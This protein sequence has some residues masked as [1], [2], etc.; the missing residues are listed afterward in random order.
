MIFRNISAR[1]SPL[2]SSPTRLETWRVPQTRWFAALR[3][4][5][6][7]HIVLLGDQL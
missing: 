4:Y 1:V 3:R 2:T 6:D 5:Y 7:E